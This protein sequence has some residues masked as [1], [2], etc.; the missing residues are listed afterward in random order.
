MKLNLKIISLLF[1]LIFSNA[2]DVM[3]QS[4]NEKCSY[5]EASIYFANPT[6]ILENY[7]KDFF[8][9]DIL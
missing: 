3:A 7:S 5:K 2:F 6:P 8:C 1:A 9:S 4:S